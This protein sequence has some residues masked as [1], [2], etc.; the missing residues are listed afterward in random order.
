M[1]KVLIID[2]DEDTIDNLTLVLESGGHSVAVKRDTGDVVKSVRQ[3][4]PDVIILDV[5]FP[6]DPQAG[7]RAA[8]ELR[9]DAACSNVPVLVL[10][11]VNQRSDMGFSFSESDIS[12]DFMPVRGFIEKPVQPAVLLQKVEDALKSLLS[13]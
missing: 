9:S 1:A 7:F 11:A 4:D 13:S 5:M 6:E 8:R 10:S 3:I 12:D 2:D